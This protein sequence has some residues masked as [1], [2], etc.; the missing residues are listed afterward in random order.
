MTNPHGK[1]KE[2]EGY[3]QINI[4]EVKLLLYKVGGAGLGSSL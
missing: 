3:I 2:L 4:L 1:Q